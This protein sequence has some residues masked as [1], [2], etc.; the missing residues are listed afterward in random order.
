MDLLSKA[1]ELTLLE[2]DNENKRINQQSARPVVL[3][4][5][6]NLMN[7][8]LI[9]Q[10]FEMRKDLELRHAESAEIGIEL[11]RAEPPILILM[12]I[13]LRGMDGYAALKVLKADPNTRHIPVIAI[14]ANAMKGDEARG[15]T[16]GFA[17][18]LTKPIDIGEFLKTIDHHL[19]ID[20][21][22]PV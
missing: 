13:N 1:N 9:R 3:Y 22:N 7:V 12:D 16:T 5:E 15:V 6:D 18:Y 4:V 20:V 2:I 14:T 8:R 19:L 10:I 11:A 21:G 17:D